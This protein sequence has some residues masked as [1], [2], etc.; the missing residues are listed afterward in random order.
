MNE[1]VITG[2]GTG[3]HIFPML[4]L[5]D[6]LRESGVPANALRFVGSRRGQEA[7]LLSGPVPVTLLAGRGIQRSWS[8]R[9]WRQNAGAVAQLIGAGAAAAYWIGRWRPAVVVSFGGY[10]SLAVSVGAV[11]WRRPL[12]LVD[13]DAVPG[14]A[15]RLVARFAARRCVAFSDTGVDV[16][17]RRVVTGVPVRPA[18]AALDRSA[19]AR[20]RARAALDPPL[21]PSRRVIVVMTGSLGAASVNQ[22]VSELASRWAD[23]ED[24]ALIHVTGRRDEA[25]VRAAQPRGARLDYR[26]IGFAD[27]ATW[28]AVADVAVSRA[29]AATIAEL[30]MLGIASVLVPLPGAPGDHQT[31]NARRVEEAGGALVLADARCTATSLGDALREVLSGETAAVMGE[32]AR[33]LA[34]P[35]AAAAIARVTR[36]VGGLR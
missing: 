10:A 17:V 24:V 12:V 22:A 13:L 14:A 18:I 7:T 15:H 21:D 28:W 31:R 5:A 29:G 27:M 36:E 1:V 11:L 8:S 4:A 9:A 19:P 23:R 32:A 26:V 2:G 6:A 16:D 34:H 33:S 3:G 35:D 30:T 25:W 20:A